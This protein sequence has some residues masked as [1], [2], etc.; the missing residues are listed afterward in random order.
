MEEEGSNVALSTSYTELQI[1]VVGHIPW[2]ALCE[3]FL[4]IFT[5]QLKYIFKNRRFNQVYI[6]FY[7]FF[8][9]TNQ[10]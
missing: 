5:L 2:L 3:F 8:R 7:Y 4:F 1:Q 6:M 9:S 10:I